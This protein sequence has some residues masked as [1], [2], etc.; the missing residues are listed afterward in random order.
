VHPTLLKRDAVGAFKTLFEDLRKVDANFFNYFR[1][2]VSTFD[3]FYTHLE[4]SLLRQNTKMRNCITT[5]E[6]LA[7]SIR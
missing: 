4:K 7:V 5:A 6:M 3:E 2:S 1:I